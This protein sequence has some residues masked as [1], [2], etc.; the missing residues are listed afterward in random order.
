MNQAQAVGTPGLLLSERKF[1]RHRE[2]PPPLKWRCNSAGTRKP[3]PP[4][5]AR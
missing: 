1:S 3:A 4:S 2:N 5:S